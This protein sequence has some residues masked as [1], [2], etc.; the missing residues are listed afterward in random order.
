MRNSEALPDQTRWRPVLLSLRPSISLLSSSRSSFIATR[1]WIERGMGNGSGPQPPLPLTVMLRYLRGEAGAAPRPALFMDRDGVLNRHIVDGYVVEPRDFEP[2][3][4]ALEAAALAQQGGAAL[5][6]VT[7]QG[8]IGRQRA[9]ESDLMVI[10]ALL[11]AELSKHGIVLDGIYVCPHHPLSPD[12]TQRDCECRK[13]KP[14]LILAA[15]DDLNLDL[16]DS[17]FIGDQPTD[18]TAARAAGIAEDRI[19]LVGGQCGVDPAQVV[20]NAWT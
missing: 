7:N 15:A 9:T 4:L 2:I 16:G 20:R 8:V 11:L 5:V 12:P 1:T 13:P 10:H 3:N 6:V 19:V 18:V 17:I 14:G